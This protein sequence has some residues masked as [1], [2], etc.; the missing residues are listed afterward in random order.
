MQYCSIGKTVL[1]TFQNQ[2]LNP[3]INVITIVIK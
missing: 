2:Y 3:L 1:Q